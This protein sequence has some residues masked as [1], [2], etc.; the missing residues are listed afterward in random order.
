MEAAGGKPRDARIIEA[1]LRT[2]GVDQYDPRVVNQLLE[3]LYR[4]VS[5]VLID[6]RN[7][8]EHTFKAQIDA[9]DIKLAIKS[10]CSHSFLQAPSREVTM[11]M[12][13]E[14]NSIPLPPVDQKAGVALPH[15]DL[16]L[17]EQLRVKVDDGQS[18]SPVKRASPT[19]NLDLSTSPKRQ[20]LSPQQRPHT[21][22]PGIGANSSSTLAQSATSP[23][24]AANARPN[25]SR[26]PDVKATQRLPSTSSPVR[27][28]ILPHSKSPQNT[29]S[30]PGISRGTAT[31]NVVQPSISKQAQIQPPQQLRQIPPGTAGSQSAPSSWTPS[32]AAMRTTS[33][34]T[35]Q[36][37]AA[38]PP[39]PT[40]APQQRP[41]LSSGKAGLPTSAPPN[42]PPP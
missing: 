1:I 16:Q 28:S 4:Y 7:V 31:A 8:C 19:R 42:P 23:G 13:A 34:I 33:Q 18:A 32:T 29:P 25:P 3:L 37:V 30:K 26:S 22:P 39:Q 36:N 12:A 27:S 20:R 38:R 6:A 21:A 9:E 17:T 15:I 14:R 5:T 35:P 41:T 24:R 10:R 2:M 40:G 11:R